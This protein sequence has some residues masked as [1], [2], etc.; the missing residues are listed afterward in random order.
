MAQKRDEPY[1]RDVY[2]DV[3]AHLSLYKDDGMP[4]LFFGAFGPDVPTTSETFSIPLLHITNLWTDR[5]AAHCR[6]HA[7]YIESQIVTDRNGRHT[8]WLH[9]YWID[10][11]SE[12]IS[13]RPPIISK[14]VSSS[15]SSDYPGTGELLGYIFLGIA[16]VA[17]GMT[18]ATLF[19][20]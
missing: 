4:K 18:K 12:E 3:I 19:G 7:C 11:N 10:R 2:N 13:D 14:R 5:F 8:L 9:F 15:S 17:F 1:I 16:S 20:I 6:K